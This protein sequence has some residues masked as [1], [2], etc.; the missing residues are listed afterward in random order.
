MILTG[1]LINTAAVI[2]GSTVGLVFRSKIQPRFIDAIFNGMGVFTLALG[3]GMALKMAQP[4]IVIFSLILGVL[5][6]EAAQ[7]DVRLEKLTARFKKEEATKNNQFAQGLI[8]SF[9][10]FCV[11]SMTLLGTLEEGLGNPPTLLYTKSLMDG[12][13]SIAIAAAF[14]SGVLFTAIPLF[15]FQASLTLMAASI[16]EVLTDAIMTDLTAVGGLII[17]ALGLSILNIKQLKVVNMLPS[18]VIVLVLYQLY[19]LLNF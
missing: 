10:L 11:G 14:G 2:I 1:T 3:T 15:I 4:L 18:L 13:S 5:L 6:G 17:I 16:K 12:F 7:L 8:F 19:P 9:L